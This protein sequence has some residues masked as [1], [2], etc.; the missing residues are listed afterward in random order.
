MA[1]KATVADAQLIAQLYDLRREAE[2][3]K[4]RSW[5]A[6]EFFPQNA[7]DFLKVAW[8]MGTQENNWLRQVGGYW[9]MVASF[10]NN[11]ALN[12]QLFLAPGFSGEMFLIY[13]KIHPFIKEL[14]EKLNDP[15]AFKDVESAVTRTKWGRHRLQFMIKR[16]EQMRERRKA[17]SSS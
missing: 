1:K 11:G 9:G 16:V 3:R 5:W 17:A 2:M 10:V 6:G 4:A 13:A 15:N 14:R 12:E 8:A 7:D